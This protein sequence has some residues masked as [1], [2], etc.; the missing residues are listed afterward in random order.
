[1]KA[2]A[3]GGGPPCC[4]A[5]L[6]AGAVPELVEVTRSQSPESP[7]AAA[8][9]AALGALAALAPGGTPAVAD[10]LVALLQP[11]SP[12]MAGNAATA[13]LTIAGG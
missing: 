2:L 3:L 5:L 11:S 12:G 9:S 13:L 10:P 4:S 1:M 6:A 8:A 7:L